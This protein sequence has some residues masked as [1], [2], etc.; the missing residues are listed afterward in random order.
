MEG[1]DFLV[2]CA[3]KWYNRSMEYTLLREN[4]KTILLRVK[5]GKV[6]VSAP[7]SAKTEDVELFLRRHAR[8]I[9][10][11]LAAQ[12]TKADF[13][14]G[15]TVE[16]M[17]KAREIREGELRLCADAVYLPRGKSG[18]FRSLLKSLSEVR[19][20]RLTQEFATRYGFTYDSVR[21]GNA[22]T[23]WGSCSDKG[24][25]SFTLRTAFLPDD[26]A[27]YLVVH[28]LCHTRHF[29]HSPAFWREAEKILP[30]CRR[31]R[32]R[33]KTYGWAMERDLEI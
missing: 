21:I 10:K 1:G 30:D 12:R 17:G 32:A 16:I 9:G 7:L 26:L 14:Y 5:G 3:G 18:A 4:R 20:G 13:S 25:I 23:R 27:V 28:E 19:M 24:K 8:W 2:I 15:S 6:I 29:D 33:L 31:L 22:R 11:R